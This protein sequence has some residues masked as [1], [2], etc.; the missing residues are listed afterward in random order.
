MTNL[1]AA[2]RY[3]FKNEGTVYTNDPDDA[4]G[5]TKFGITKK[6][7]E[8][9]FGHAVQNSEIENMT[10]AI[11]KQIYAAHYWAP[12]RCGEIQTTGFA[13]AF[14][15]TA[16][17]YGVGTTA[18]LIQRSLSLCGASLKLNAKID[19]ETVR[20]INMIGGGSPGTRS[21]LMKTFHGLIL[22][23]IES[24][25]TARPTNEKYRRGWTNRTDR[26]LNLLD[27]DFVSQLKQESQRI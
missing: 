10:P 17:L 2:F 5:P 19:D 1:D 11:A 26:L 20:F 14:F 8:K 3:L 22:E 24:V 13:I 25:I 15:D 21:S 4:G 16:V 27:D 18:L 7:Y 23:R 6:T 9:F 12:I